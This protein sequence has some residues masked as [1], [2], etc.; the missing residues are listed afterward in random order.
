M[1]PCHWYLPSSLGVAG[2]TSGA[3]LPLWLS[4]SRQDLWW[5][6]RRCPRRKRHTARGF[7]FAQRPGIDP[8]A[9][10]LL[11]GQAPLERTRTFPPGNLDDSHSDKLLSI[12]AFGAL[13]INK[14]DHHFIFPP[15]SPPCTR[16]L[17]LFHAIFGTGIGQAPS[18]GNPT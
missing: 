6:E 2:N 14:L 11:Q 1:V 12:Y 9:P 16:G 8:G 3:R 17:G 18:L 10:P 13:P 15:G 4:R 5:P 7:P